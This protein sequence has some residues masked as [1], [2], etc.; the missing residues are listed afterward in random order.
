MTANI[1]FYTESAKDAGFVKLAERFKN[2]SLNGNDLYLHDI[3]E[4]EQTACKNAIEYIFCGFNFV[5]TFKN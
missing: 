4:T 3:A 1:C 5:L 2:Y